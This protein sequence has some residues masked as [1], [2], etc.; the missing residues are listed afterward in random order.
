[1]SPI[2]LLETILYEPK[3]GFFLLDKH[4]DRMINSAKT[5]ACFLSDDQE[6]FLEDLIPTR[7]E[8]VNKLESAIKSSG[9]DSRQRLRLLLAFDGAVM[10]QSSQLPSETNNFSGSPPIVALDREPTQKDNIF[11]RHKTTERT[12]YN[13]A[14]TRRGL[15]PIGGPLKPDEPLDVIMFNEFDEIT[16][17]SIANIAIE[18]E[19]PDTG[20]LEWVTPPLSSGLLGGTMRLYLLEKGEIRERVITVDELKLAVMDNRRIKCFNS[21]RKEYLVKV[22]L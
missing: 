21:V 13:D 11:L 17:T 3:E 9:K 5:L 7:S 4:C 14:R 15:G 12:A 16:E 1:M 8:L 6:K 19:S 20:K 22:V 2:Q 18:M 10:I